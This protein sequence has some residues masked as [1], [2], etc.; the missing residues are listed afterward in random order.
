MSG[1]TP[2]HDSLLSY[3][4]KVVLNS[5]IAWHSLRRSSLSSAYQ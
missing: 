2:I 4:K 1:I 3:L 5:K